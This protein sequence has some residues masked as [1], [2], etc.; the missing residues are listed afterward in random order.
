MDWVCK[1][2][3]FCFAEMVVSLSNKAVA[4]QPAPAY[5]PGKDGYAD[6]VILAFQGFKEYFAHDYRTLMAVL[7]EIQ[8]IAKS[9]GLTAET[10]PHFSIVCARW[11]AILNASVELH[12]LGDIRAL[13]ATGVDRVQVSQHYMK[14]TDYTF[15]AVKTTL[16]IDSETSL[17]LYIHC[18]MK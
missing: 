8:R 4:G 18:S 2:K 9:L 15:E 6:L 14:R 17:I 16:L 1:T 7:R 3:T 5:R 11:R 12:E 10:L 13:N